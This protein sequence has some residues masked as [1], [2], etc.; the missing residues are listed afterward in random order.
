M[1]KALQDA[2]AKWL[3]T[4]YAQWS[5][6]LTTLVLTV[7][8]TGAVASWG[9][10]YY[11]TPNTECFE[12]FFYLSLLW[13]LV[14]WIVIGFMYGYKTIPMFARHAI[15]LLILLSNAWFILF[16]FSLRPCGG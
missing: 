11:S 10:F 12:G 16:I 7:L 15:Q 13:L 14:Q 6:I 4:E 9:Y 2:K 5:N 1:N 3:S 8:V